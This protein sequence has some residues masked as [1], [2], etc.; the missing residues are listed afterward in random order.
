MSRLLQFEAY[1]SNI[2]KIIHIYFEFKI[3]MKD[4]ETPLSQL[5]W[6]L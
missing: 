1:V 4:N 2:L 3:D 5:V 6:K